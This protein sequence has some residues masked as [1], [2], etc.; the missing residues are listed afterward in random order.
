M[1]NICSSGTGPMVMGILNINN[2]SFYSRSRHTALEDVDATLCKMVEDG[3]DIIDIGACSTRPGSTPV[4]L[5]QEW[6]YLKEPLEL[7]AG[8]Y[9]HSGEHREL[10]GR[11]V[12]ISID[13]FR[14][15]IV[16]RAYGLLGDFIVNDIS[17]GEDDP[18]MLSTVGELGLPYIAMHKRGTPSTMQQMTDYPQGVVN[19]VV[20]YFRE[21]EQRAAKYGIKEYVMDPGFG[22]AK[23]LEQNYLLFK[24]MPQLVDEI[25]EYAGKKRKLLVGISRKGMIW[26]PLGITPDEALCGTAALNLQ[27][28]LLGADILRVHDVAE[29]RQCIKLWELLR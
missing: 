27:A 12:Q 24:A 15:E 5:E 23:N 19:A 2:E 1:T 4:S 29:A 10:S 21:F 22:F 26:K 8:K 14:S 28:L 25:E 3:A 17:A 16:R 11:K 20:E 9:L 7:I 13:T 18:L 6:E